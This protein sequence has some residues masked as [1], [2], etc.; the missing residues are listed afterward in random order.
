MGNLD[1]L[2]VSDMAGPLLADFGESIS[3]TPSG[4]SPCSIQ[5]IVHR[6]LPE[7]IN[8]SLVNTIDIEIANHPTLGIQTVTRMGDVVTVALREGATPG[9]LKV[10]AIVAQDPGYWRLRLR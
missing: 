3:Y 6:E 9:P 7:T 10:V 2:L 1:S 5:A 8:S 4:G